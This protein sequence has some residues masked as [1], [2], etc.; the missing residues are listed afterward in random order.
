[1]VILIVIM[2]IVTIVMTIIITIIAIVIVIGWACDG[3]DFPGGCKSGV[4]DF[5]ML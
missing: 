5:G 1:M 2:T 4:A 3:R